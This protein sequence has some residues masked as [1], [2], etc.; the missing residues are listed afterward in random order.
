[1]RA[2]HEHER[3]EA[4]QREL[5]ELQ[6]TL[7]ELTAQHND[8]QSRLK[9]LEDS[10]NSAYQRLLGELNTTRHTLGLEREKTIKANSQHSVE[11][12]LP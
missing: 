11:V 9:A 5:S 10:S 7:R 6:I 8:S 4:L 2:A 1:V 3:A 12:S